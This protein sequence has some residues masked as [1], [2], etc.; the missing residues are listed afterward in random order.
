[1]NSE[2]YCIDCMEYMR[3]LPDKAFDLAVVDPPYGIGEGGQKAKTRGQQADFG[4][5]HKSNAKCYSRS[6]YVCFE[7]VAPPE[8][9]FR[10]LERVSRNQI[11]W[12]GNHLAGRIGKDSPCWLVWD[13]RNDANDFAD[14]EL[15]YTSFRTAV[16]VFRFKWNGMLQEDMKHKEYRIHPTQKPV[17]L[18]RWIFRNYAKA[19]D[20]VLDTHMGSG[21]SRIAAYEAGL[22]YVGCEINPAMFELEEKRFEEYTAQ[23]SLFTG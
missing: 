19:G 12:G 8:E 10:E 7:D 4:K 6:D 3:T 15:A 23:I 20:R 5:P 11:I 9:Y 22:D 13:K 2:T 21:S 1:M 16:R 14:C 17:A 18:Y